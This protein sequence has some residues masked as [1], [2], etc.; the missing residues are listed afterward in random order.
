LLWTDDVSWRWLG[1]PLLVVLFISNLWLLERPLLQGLLVLQGALYACSVLGY[2]RQDTPASR[3][4]ALPLYFSL[5]NLATLLG[6]IQIL[7][8]HRAA[9]WPPGGRR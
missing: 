4:L 5:S 8:R 6:L 3:W 7:R 1:A 2:V 9:T